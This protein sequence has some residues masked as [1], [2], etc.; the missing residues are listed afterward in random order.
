MEYTAHRYRIIIIPKLIKYR[1][2]L[3]L[4]RDSWLTIFSG[5]LFHS[6]IGEGTK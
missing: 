3:K 4:D 5:R 6:L 2:S 1:D